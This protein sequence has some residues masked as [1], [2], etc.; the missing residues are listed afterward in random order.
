M[1]FPGNVLFPVILVL[2]V[3]QWCMNLRRLK[4]DIFEHYF[5]SCLSAFPHCGVAAAVEAVAAAAWG[6]DVVIIAGCGGGGGIS[7]SLPS[8]R[9][10]SRRRSEGEE[11]LPSLLL[12]Q[13]KMSVVDI[14]DRG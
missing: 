4:I 8:K 13:V 10:S 3:I 12:Q 6:K 11:D 1:L 14:F 9:S 7:S 5:V 2:F